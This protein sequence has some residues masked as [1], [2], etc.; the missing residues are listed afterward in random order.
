[1]FFLYHSLMLNMGI[2][3][4]TAKSKVSG[5]FVSNAVV[6]AAL[7]A[8]SEYNVD[9]QT[10][11]DNESSSP[12]TPLPLNDITLRPIEHSRKTNDENISTRAWN[13]INR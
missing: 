1:M 13:K 4:R 6:H 5:R 2:S 8:S 3:V 10:T 9:H 12:P 11:R 7:A